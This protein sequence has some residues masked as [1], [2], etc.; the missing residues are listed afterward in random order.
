MI[1]AAFTP[2]IAPDASTSGPPEFPGFTAASVWITPSIS[3]PDGERMERPSA[4]TIPW[5]T[6]PSNP[7]GEPTAR[8]S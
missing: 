6:L 7:R 1:V 8:T 2:T 3:R 4:L 5:D